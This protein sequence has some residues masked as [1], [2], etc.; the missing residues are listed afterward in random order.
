M[1]TKTDKRHNQFLEI[2]LELRKKQKASGAL[3]KITVHKILQSLTQKS[4]EFKELHGH[5]KRK[6]EPRVVFWPAEHNLYFK[7]GAKQKWTIC[8]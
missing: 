3:K 4:S 7:S 8:Q 1:I 6:V 2:N 5:L